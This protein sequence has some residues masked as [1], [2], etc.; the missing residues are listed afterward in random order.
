M[1]GFWRDILHGGGAHEAP[2]PCRVLLAGGRPLFLCL[3]PARWDH[4]VIEIIAYL[5]SRQSHSD[6]L[7]IAPGWRHFYLRYRL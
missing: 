2:P 4:L 6:S 5:L 7:P 1:Y 3:P